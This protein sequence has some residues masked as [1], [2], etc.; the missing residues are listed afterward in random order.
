M[1]AVEGKELMDTP[2]MPPT[3]EEMDMM[4]EEMKEITSTNVHIFREVFEGMMGG[5][6]RFPDP[7]LAFIMQQT[8]KLSTEMCGEYLRVMKPIMKLARHYKDENES[9][10]QE[11]DEMRQKL[12]KAKLGKE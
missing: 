9:L 8:M 5:Y 2:Y 1:C 6:E 11:L 4:D 3:S 10:H 7:F 12:M